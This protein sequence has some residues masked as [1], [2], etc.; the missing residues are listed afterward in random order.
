MGWKH[1]KKHGRSP[2]RHKSREAQTNLAQIAV[3]TKTPTNPKYTLHGHR[4]RPASF[5]G[6]KM[7]L[8]SLL[9]Q[10]LRPRRGGGTPFPA[11]ARLRHSS[12]ARPAKAAASTPGDARDAAPPPPMLPTR[13]WEEALAA[14][15]RGFSLPLAGR[16]LAASATGNAAVSPSAVHASLALAAAGARGATRRQVVQALCGGGGGGRGAAA[17][18]ANVASRVVKRV[19]RD[20]STSG[21]PRVAFAAGVW[22]DASTKLSPGFVEAARDVY[23][24]VAKTADFVNEVSNSRF[25]C[26]SCICL[27]IVRP[28]ACLEL[29][30]KHPDFLVAGYFVTSSLSF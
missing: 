27:S 20:R 23:G 8:S 10:A 13:P 5:A 12:S 24:C 4:T 30:E 21:G 11:D 9:R 19:L 16:V 1:E 22:A 26:N 15:Q 18:A 29:K 25:K 17:D 6:E 2:A 3:K 7:Q 28:Y 14:A